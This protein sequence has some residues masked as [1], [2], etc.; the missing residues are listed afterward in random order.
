MLRVADLMTVE[1]QTVSIDATLREVVEKM[2]AEAFR[3][4]PVLDKEEQLVGIVTD[5]DIRLVMHSP[6]LLHERWQD[7]ALLSTSLVETVMTRN[8]ITVSPSTSAGKAADMLSAYKIGALPVVEGDELV[9][10]LT[11]T[12]FLDWFAQEHSDR[13]EET[14]EAG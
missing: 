14:L 5:R 3:H 6:I 4:M 8:P 7:E 9:G 2:R 13:A 1:V 10:I 12:D 11:T